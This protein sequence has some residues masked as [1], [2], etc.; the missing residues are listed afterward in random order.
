M[1]PPCRVA[2][3]PP[4]T[5]S[6]GSRRAA[7]R[8]ST[9]GLGPNRSWSIAI[10]TGSISSRPRPAPPF[11]PAF[12]PTANRASCRAC[13]CIGSTRPI[14]RLVSRHRRA[15]AGGVPE[16]PGHFCC[17]WP[18]WAGPRCG[19]TRPESS[20]RPQSCGRANKCW[21]LGIHPQG[22]GTARWSQPTE[23]SGISVASRTICSAR[24][25]LVSG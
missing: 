5:S 22:R 2:A 8:R 13:R 6:T 12:P 25:G 11:W 17:C 21:R 16:P 1:P 18:R 14:W 19:P 7:G 24:S 23:G 9:G 20:F 3:I 4:I 10:G 15:R